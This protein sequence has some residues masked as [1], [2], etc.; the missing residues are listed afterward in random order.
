M[1]VSKGSSTFNTQDLTT[2]G[3]TLIELVIGMLVFAIA[4]SLFTSLVIPQA[5]QS[6]D[7][8]FQVRATELAQ[9]LLNEI[10]GKAF[11]E[12]SSRVGGGERCSEVG[13]PVC[14][15]S[16]DLGPEELDLGGAGIRE[17]FDDVDDYNGLSVIENSLGA[18]ITVGSLN[19]YQGFSASVAV[20]YDS[21][22]DGTNDGAVG[23]AKLITVTITTPNNENIAFSTDRY[24]Y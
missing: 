19:L 12:Q 8:I 2:K 6:V 20:I 16:D 9:S 21:N 17:N 11:D 13:Q 4:L 24:N 1:P 15:A 22:L 18:S 23:N 10:A 5:R 7:P 3:F 14:T